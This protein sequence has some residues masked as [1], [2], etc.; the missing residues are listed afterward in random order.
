MTPTTIRGVSI[1][2]AQKKRGQDVFDIALSREGIEVRRPE[3]PSSLTS[4]DRVSEWEVEEHNGYVLLTLRGQGATT[5]LVVPGWRLDDL[6][7]LMRDV[8][9]NG[10]AK[11]TANA[12]VPGP[13]ENG[14]GIPAPAA[15]A[16][17]T[18]KPSPASDEPPGGDPAAETATE[19]E[20]ERAARRRVPWKAV[21]TISILGV[22]ATAVLLVLLQSAGIIDWSF[23]GPVA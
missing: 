20:T 6:E 3:R 12:P 13:A 11:D 21:A 14:D 16:S 4:W 8:T 2:S 22:L 17:T 5:P 7:I 15:K 18:V 9:S 19:K 10:T 23:L 1:L